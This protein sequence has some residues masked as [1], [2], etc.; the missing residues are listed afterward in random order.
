MNLAQVI[1]QRWAAASP[2]NDLLPA[3]RVYTGTSVDPTLPYAVIC[4]ESG[5]PV[6]RHNDGSAVDTVGV[7]IRVFGDNRDAAA[8]IV[9]QVKLAFDR[10]AFELAGSDK[11]INMQ[12]S[13]DSER[14]TDDS[15]WEMTVDFDCTV[16]LASGV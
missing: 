16:Y 7:R 10:T 6:G 4:R 8:A 3:G 2:L 5:R 12:R 11:V 1:H 9:H 13:A 14:Q 15:L